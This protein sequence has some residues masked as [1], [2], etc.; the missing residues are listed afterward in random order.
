MPAERRSSGA[1][2]GDA[3]STAATN[4][5]LRR[6]ATP[7]ATAASTKPYEASELDAH[8]TASPRT[9]SAYIHANASA[10][11]PAAI[12]SRAPAAQ[13][14]HETEKAGADQQERC[15]FG[16]RRQSRAAA[17]AAGTD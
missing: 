4:A 2:G 17:R 16:R 10:T 5:R 7:S 12:I 15:W 13:D 8:W 11:R 14:A 1:A 6:Q 3:E 9:T